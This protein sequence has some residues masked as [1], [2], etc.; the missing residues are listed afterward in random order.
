MVILRFVSED[1]QIICLRQIPKKKK[2]TSEQKSADFQ[3]SGSDNGHASIQK[4]KRLT[5]KL[6]YELENL[7]SK[8]QKIE[9]DIEALSMKLSDS[10]FYKNDKERFLETSKE[11]EKSKADLDFYETRWLELEEQNLL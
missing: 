4:T 11:L 9:K 2:K 5:Y 7:P 6:K 1:I 8:I 3:K 10:N